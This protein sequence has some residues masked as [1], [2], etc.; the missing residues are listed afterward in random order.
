MACHLF[1][2][3]SLPEPMLIYYSPALLKWVGLEAFLRWCPPSTMWA[4]P[5]N[6]FMAA[7]GVVWIIPSFWIWGNVLHVEHIWCVITNRGQHQ[8][9]IPSLFSMAL[10]ALLEENITKKLLSLSLDLFFKILLFQVTFLIVRRAG[11]LWSQQDFEW[12]WSVPLSSAS[13]Y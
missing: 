7:I 8:W 5:F 12:W 9:A 13:L 10:E 11:L 4:D 1:S 2:T 6:L 3:K